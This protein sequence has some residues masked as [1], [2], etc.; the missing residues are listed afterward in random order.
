MRHHLLA[1]ALILVAAVPAQAA[2]MAKLDTGEGKV[3]TMRWWRVPGG[4]RWTLTCL[5]DSTNTRPPDMATYRGV[6][7]LEDGFLEGKV[8]G[9]F[10]GRF[11]LATRGLAPYWQLWLDACPERG[12]SPVIREVR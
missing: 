6:S 1:T 12:G 8:A 7:R 10:G 3:A 11:V 9:E 5:D 2:H 4:V